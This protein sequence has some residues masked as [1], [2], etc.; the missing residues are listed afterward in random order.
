MTRKFLERRDYRKIIKCE[1]NG[2]EN[3][4]HSSGITLFGRGLERFFF[5]GKR[6][7]KEAVYSDGGRLYSAV[8]IGRRKKQKFEVSEAR[9]FVKRRRTDYRGEMKR[10]ASLRTSSM[11]P[12]HHP[13]ST[14]R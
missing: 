10:A 14:I 13:L 4:T 11:C 8:G 6:R 3:V 7:G 2:G 5:S 9:G 12:S 1:K